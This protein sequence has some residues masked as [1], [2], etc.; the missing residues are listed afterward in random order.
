MTQE[1]A[2]RV[3]LV[4]PSIRKDSFDRFVQEWSTTLGPDGRTIFERCSLVL[5]EDN[6]EPT[7]TV[8]LSSEELTPTHLSWRDIDQTLGKDAWVIPRRSDTVRSFAYWWAW[9]EG[10]DYIM[11]LDDDCY[12]Q[13]GYPAPD[14]AHLEALTGRSRWFNTLTN[15]KPRGV[16]FKNIGVGRRNVLNHGLWTHVLDYDAPTQLVAP[17]E[18]TMP[19]DS[20]T[21]P[22]G[23]YYPMCGMN[24]MWRA[25][26]TYAMYH[27]LMGCVDGN[28]LPAKHSEAGHWQDSALVKL[29][30]DR[31]GDIWAG[32]LSKKLFDEYGLSVTTGVPYIHHDRASDPFVNLRKEANGLQV[33][34]HLWELVDEGWASSRVEWNDALYAYQAICDGAFSQA[35]RRWP[36][37]AAYFSALV[38][39]CGVWCELFRRSGAGSRPFYTGLGEHPGL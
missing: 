13:L 38:D 26:V 24:L 28:S 22:G 8:D 16:P 27:L 32:L 4:V 39:A 37:H 31:F 9:R 1:N 34:E 29:A 23:L 21:V 5:M 11:T 35:A 36:E 18:E 30:F 15:V 12:P 2:P 10:F 25:D 3:A 7:F 17:V 14:L 33:N 20:R 6:P 19:H